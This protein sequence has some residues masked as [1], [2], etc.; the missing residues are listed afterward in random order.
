MAKKYHQGFKG[1]YCTLCNTVWEFIPSVGIVTHPDFP[2]YGLERE[3]CSKCEG[4][5]SEI[6]IPPTLAE[7]VAEQRKNL[8]KKEVERFN[9]EIEKYNR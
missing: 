1:K 8:F 4:V 9:K 3:D 7:E 5:S 6:N 2:S